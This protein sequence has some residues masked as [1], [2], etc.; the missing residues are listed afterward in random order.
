M[1][2]IAHVLPSGGENPLETS[3]VHLSS[4]LEVIVTAMTAESMTP[5]ATPIAEA[6]ERMMVGF[7]DNWSGLGRLPWSGWCIVCVVVGCVLDF[8]T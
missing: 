8:V 6:F 2:S 1:G 4:A 3:F 5:T 7:G